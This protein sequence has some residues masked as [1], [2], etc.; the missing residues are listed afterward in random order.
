MKDKREKEKRE[1][2][3]EKERKKQITKINS[4][5]ALCSQ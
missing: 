4:R 3:K 1:E 5:A 2:S